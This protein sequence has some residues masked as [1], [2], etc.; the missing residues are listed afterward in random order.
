MTRTWEGPL[1]DAGLL[2]DDIHD[3]LR[4]AQPLTELEASWHAE[5]TLKSLVA[6]CGK[7]ERELNPNLECVLGFLRWENT[8][9]KNATPVRQILLCIHQSS[10]S[11]P[12]KGTAG[13]HFPGFVFGEPM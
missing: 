1:C 12:P 2:T 8:G 5:S 9:G 7:R 3:T 6:K 13:L 10:F 11:F 4:I